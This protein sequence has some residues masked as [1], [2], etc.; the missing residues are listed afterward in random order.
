MILKKA[1]GVV[2]IVLCV[3]L[4]LLV[5]LNLITW[6]LFWMGIILLAGFAWFVLPNLFE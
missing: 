1:L 4:L 6:R 5:A 3:S 2:G